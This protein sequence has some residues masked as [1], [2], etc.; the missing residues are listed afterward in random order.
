MSFLF[1]PTELG[2]DNG[3]EIRAKMD[4]KMDT[5]TKSKLTHAI[6]NGRITTYS[7]IP[8]PQSL[9]LTWISLPFCFLMNVGVGELQMTSPPLYFICISITSPFELGN[10]K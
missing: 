9:S 3:V 1:P 2:C 7:Y 6:K 10:I 8:Q 4:E 5:M